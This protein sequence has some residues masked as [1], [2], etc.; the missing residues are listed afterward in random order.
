MI[1]CLRSAGEVRA[2]EFP[3]PGVAR[4][5]QV[6]RVRV[7]FRELPHSTTGKRVMIISGVIAVNHDDVL[8]PRSSAKTRTMRGI[9][10]S[11]RDGVYCVLV[12]RSQVHAFT[13]LVGASRW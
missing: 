11:V 5:D 7:I 1:Y 3:A 12:V 2:V 6:T 9:R 4:D 13:G 10:G 8:D